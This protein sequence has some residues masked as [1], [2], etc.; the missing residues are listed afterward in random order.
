MAFSLAPRASCVRWCIDRNH[1][2]GDRYENYPD[3]NNSVYITKTVRPLHSFEEM[4]AV[5]R[6]RARR[7]G[8]AEAKINATLP[9]KYINEVFSASGVGRLLPH[10]L[11]G[12]PDVHEAE[13]NDFVA[14]FYHNRSFGAVMLRLFCDNG[15]LKSKPV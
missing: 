9:E 7:A 12:H 13:N 3:L 11:G 10:A 2:R 8:E 5:L 6:Q 14:H 15:G 4:S 1:A